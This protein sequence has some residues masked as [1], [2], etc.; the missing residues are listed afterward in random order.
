MAISDE[1]RRI[2][3]SNPTDKFY[4]ETI[5]LAHPVFENGISYFTNQN[6][7]WVGN[8]E[9]GGQAAYQYLPFVTLPPASEDEAALTLQVTMDNSSRTLM[10]TLEF[11][12]TTPQQPIEVVYRIYIGTVTGGTVQQSP[13]L[14]NDPPLRLWVSSVLATQDAVSFSA[15]TSNL[16]DLPFPRQLYTTGL[17][18]GLE[19]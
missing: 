2:Y 5:S 19:R 17:Y 4:V 1:L 13:I 3:A 12:G 16:R 8:L 7:G 11:M 18:P 15:T 14:Q 10:E 9:A 6:G